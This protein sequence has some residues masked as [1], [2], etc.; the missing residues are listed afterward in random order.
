[1]VLPAR[2]V[3][4]S[5]ASAPPPPAS[6]LTT[7]MSG[8]S[9]YTL[10]R[11]IEVS[12]NRP[13]NMPLGLAVA[14]SKT[15]HLIVTDVPHGGLVQQLHADFRLGDMLISINGLEVQGLDSFVQLMSELSGLL[16][17][18]I[19]RVEDPE[20]LQTLL[21][22]VSKEQ[23]RLESER[24][25]LSQGIR[26]SQE[27]DLLDLAVQRSLSEAQCNLSTES[28]EDVMLRKAIEASKLQAQEDEAVAKARE[29]SALEQ[30]L[31]V[32]QQSVATLAPSAADDRPSP[33]PSSFPPPPAN[34]PP[35]YMPPPYMPP[36]SLTRPVTTSL[37]PPPT[38]A[39]IV[40]PSNEDS[41]ERQPSSAVRE[42][43]DAIARNRG[44]DG[45]IQTT[46]AAARVQRQPSRT[47]PMST[48][49]EPLQRSDSI[50]A[51]YAAQ[52]HFVLTQLTRQSLFEADESSS[53]DD[54][55]KDDA[56]GEIGSRTVSK[57]V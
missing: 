3:P 33:P 40:S 42:L 47:R 30:A 6:R 49:S 9:E 35:P 24:R 34:T 4:T 27:H 26:A 20:A 12:F 57:F 11:R 37:P 53:D 19:Q 15:G 10:C 28:E 54:E 18:Q 44:H 52:T 13:P 31:H 48:A 50:Q 17:F 38:L 36:P 43:E 5:A 7:E 22:Q 45:A 23:H 8:R 1:M 25:N 56:G 32:S 39:D 29:A 14:P 16:A 51:C 46:A 55:D 2:C 41:R 21:Q